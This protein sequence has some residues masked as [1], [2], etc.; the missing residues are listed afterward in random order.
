[1][2]IVSNLLVGLIFGFIGLLLPNLRTI[3]MLEG[4]YI[5]V[6]FIHILASITLIIFTTL[7]AKGVIPFM[8]GNS[9][10]GGLAVSYLSYKKKERIVS[11]I[12]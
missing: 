3:K 1:M 4:N 10:G 6:F 12:F 8:I 5:Q 2:I 9:I 11:E 7:V